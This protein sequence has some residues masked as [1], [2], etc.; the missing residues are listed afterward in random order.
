MC[1]RSSSPQPQP[2]PKEDPSIARRE[3]EQNQTKI[4]NQKDTTKGG[5]GDAVVSGLKATYT[6]P[7]FIYDLINP[8]SPLPKAKDF[9]PKD[10]NY[11]AQM[12]QLKKEDPTMYY[13]MLMSEGVDP[14]INLNIPVQLEFEQK[15]PQFG[16]QYSD[17]LTQNKAEGGITGLRS[18]YEY[19]K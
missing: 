7:K 13:K 17:A 16:T 8:L 14:R 19:K 6:Q 15:Y 1:M 10:L 4:A 3:A 11:K 5:I 9:F 18:K 12:E 2:I